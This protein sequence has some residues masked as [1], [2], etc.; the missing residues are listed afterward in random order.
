MCFEKSNYVIFQLPVATSV[1]GGTRVTNSSIHPPPTCKN[2]IRKM[3]AEDSPTDFMCLWPPPPPST[4]TTTL[5]SHW[6]YAHE[7]SLFICLK[8]QKQ[9]QTDLTVILPSVTLSTGFWTQSKLTIRKLTGLSRHPW[10]R[11]TPDPLLS[12]HYPSPHPV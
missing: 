8:K 6:F 10:S 2:I 12:K 5:F 11:F 4:G 1:Q 7:H 9:I 3:A